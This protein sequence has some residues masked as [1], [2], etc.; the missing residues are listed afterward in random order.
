MRIALVS[1]YFAPE[2]TPVT[3]LYADLAAD[4]TAYGA[5]VT[6]VT[7]QP[8]RGL[9][10]EEYSAYLA[11]TDEKTP[12]GYRILR[13]GGGA[14]EGRGLLSRGLY[15]IKSTFAL[16]RAARDAQADVYLLGSMP[17]MLGLV[18]AKLH[19]RAA[20]V[21][22]LQDI[23]PDTLLL[24]GK[25][26]ETHPVV[27][28]CRWMERATYRRNTRFLTLSQ[29]MAGTLLRRGVPQEKLDVVENWTDTEAV[30][31]VERADNPLFDEFELDRGGFYALYAGV[32]G[33]LQ[34]PDALLDAAKLL[35][36][37]PEITLVI[38]GGG[39]FAPAV[40][41]RIRDERIQN[42]RYYPMQR[43]ERVPLVYSIGDVCVVP[44][45]AG[46]TKAAM[47][48]KTWS[49]LA[50]GR[51]AIVAAEA[52][53]TLARIMRENGCGFVAEPGSAAALA[54]AIRTAYERRSALPR[55]G[56]NGRA[57]VKAHLSRGA[58]TKRYFAILQKAE[59]ERNV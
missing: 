24:M 50:C 22:I 16:Y 51:P 1:V 26:S 29:D 14:R 40:Q 12:E 5:E 38:V 28:L 43:T 46:T 8:N 20:T 47:P 15:L 31:P 41:K 13:V 53:T 25:F 35:A 34:E 57:Y 27:R 18:G 37:V 10:R 9:S 58:Q 39:T 49:I 36:D 17:P 23:F 59:A 7:G 32:L 6:V 48:S 33:A 55:M 2:I 56:E 3:H 4:L 19:K 11:R 52:D 30:A 44:L 42:V 54:E 45:K 21:Y